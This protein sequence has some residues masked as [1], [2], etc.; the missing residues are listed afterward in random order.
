M[1][2]NERPGL[3]PGVKA[4]IRRVVTEADCASAIGSGA[5]PVLSTP[6]LIA[7]MELAAMEA[8][9]P[10]LRPGETTVGTRVEVVH[11]E[12]CPP[13]TEVEAEAVLREM[14]GRRLRFDVA[15]TAGGTLLGRGCHE[16]VI[17]DRER[18]LARL[19]GRWE[20]P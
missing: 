15:V 13:G 7:W 9:A 1:T 11:L 3:V 18:F 16:R 4:A 20:R 8:A 17:V 14:E 12:A 2:D 19:A 6:H 5:V 10:H